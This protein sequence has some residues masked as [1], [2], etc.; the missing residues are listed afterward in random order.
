M[1]TFNVVLTMMMMT[2]VLMSR[3]DVVDSGVNGVHSDRVEL[4]EI[5]MTSVLTVVM[6]MMILVLMMMMTMTLEVIVMNLV[7]TML[8]VDDDNQ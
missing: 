3:V 2:R 7:L 6:T 5:M 4:E 8:G 1:L